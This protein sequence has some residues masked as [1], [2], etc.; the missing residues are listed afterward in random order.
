MEHYDCARAVYDS[1]DIDIDVK[2]LCFAGTQEELNDTAVA[3]PLHPD[4]FFGHRLGVACT[5]DRS[6]RCGRT[7]PGGI[8]RPAYAGVFTPA[9]GAS[10]VRA[11]GKIMA[12]ALP[13]GTSGM[14]AVL[15]TEAS[16]I[17]EVCE[18]VRT[19]GVCEIANYNCPGQIVISGQKAAV[20]AATEKLKE[21]G[22]RRVIP[23]AVSGAFH[24]SLLQEASQKLE[25]V[26][27]TYTFASPG[28][29]VIANVSGV[30]EAR[31]LKEVLKEQI[32]HSVQ[33]TQSIE[34][35]LAMGIDTFIEIGPGHSLSGF[36][37]KTSR[38]VKTYSIDTVADMEKVLQEVHAHEC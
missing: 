27:Q 5:R 17:R 1:V 13:A 11:R 15:N 14:A 19:I 33:F 29:P 9:Q 6:V 7:E 35:M 34:T 18:E 32:C 30:Q 28:V 3:Q 2:Q 4:D 12:E 22:A 25:Q 38:D 23:L 8:F 10:L 20:E 36:V 24:T 21:R 31:D 37:R 26:L 16:V